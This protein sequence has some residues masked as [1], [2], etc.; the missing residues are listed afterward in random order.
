MALRWKM[1][2]KE[3]GLRAVAASPRSH[4]LR[5]GENRLACVSAL[6][7]SADSW[8]FVAGWDGRDVI[9]HENTCATP[10]A[11]I[12]EAKSL[13]LAYVKRYWSSK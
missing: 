2:P 9:P 1:E 5:D 7:R 4:W 10:A 6:S 11:T 12:E 13:A 8:Y 3:T